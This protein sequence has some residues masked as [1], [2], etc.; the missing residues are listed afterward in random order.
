LIKYLKIPIARQ[1]HGG[2]MR[3]GGRWSSRRK[4]GG[5]REGGWRSG[6]GGGLGGGGYITHEAITLTNTQPMI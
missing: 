1:T 3:N 6:R 5:G 4:G 2:G